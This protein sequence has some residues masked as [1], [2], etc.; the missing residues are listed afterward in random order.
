M[1]RFCPMERLKYCETD[2]GWF[3]EEKHECAMLVLAKA[4]HAAD[5]QR[6]AAIRLQE[7]VNLNN[8][9]VQNKLL[10]YLDEASEALTA[11]MHKEE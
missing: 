1:Q 6:H 8:I 4:T 3:D 5:P 2:C 9:E 7:T 10:K 11:E